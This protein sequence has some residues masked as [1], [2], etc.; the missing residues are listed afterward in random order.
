M[1]RQRRLL[2]KNTTGMLTPSPMKSRKKL[3]WDAPATAS[4]LSKDMVMLAITRIF[5]AWLILVIPSSTDVAPVLKTRRAH[6]QVKDY[7]AAHKS[8]EAVFQKFGDKV[9]KENAQYNGDA[10]AKDMALKRRCFGRDLRATATTIALSTDLTRLMMMTLKRAE[11]Q[12]QLKD[13]V[14]RFPS[15]MIRLI[16]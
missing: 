8:D 4:I 2:A 5:T 15:P 7:R 3:P 11:I 6:R 12:I 13:I 10:S 14:P 16:E 9:S 1:T